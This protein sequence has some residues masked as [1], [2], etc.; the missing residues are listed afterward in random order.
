M[1][2]LKAIAIG[3]D[4]GLPSDMACEYLW[5]DLDG[6]AA[7]ASLTAALYRLRKL[8]GSPDAIRLVEGRLVL[9]PD[10]TWVDLHAFDRLA[11]SDD[12]TERA[13]AL[14]IYRGTLLPDDDEPWITAPRVRVR[15]AFARLVERIAAP[16]E[17]ADPDAAEGLYLRAIEADPL[18]EG[19]YRG[20]MRCHA[21]RGQLAEVAAVHRRLRQTLSVILGIAP[22]A[23]TERLRR[24]IVEGA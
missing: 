18:A 3:G 7:A 17:E 20:L 2:L 12:A 6:D 16:L 15:D 11:Q 4:R 5:P 19:C 1:A 23:E 13:Q 9:L 14:A 22:S 10:A 8:L 21:A 24:T